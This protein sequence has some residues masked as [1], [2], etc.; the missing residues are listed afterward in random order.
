MLIHD[1][2]E[3][4][5]RRGTE[6]K[7][8]DTFPPDVLPMWI[9]DTDFKCPQPIV[10]AMV[11]RAQQ[12]IYG[13]PINTRKFNQA[14][15]AWEKKRFGWEVDEDWVEFTPAVMPAVVYA[16]QMFTQAGDHI[17]IQMPV[18]PPIH[19]AVVNNGRVISNNQL[20]LRDGQYEVDFHDLEKRLAHPRA[21]MMIL[22]HPHNPVGKAFTRDELQRIG[23]LCAKH[24]VLLVSDEIHQD[25][26]Y[27]GHRHF[28]FASLSDLHRDNSIICINPS[29]TFNIAGVRTGAVIIPNKAIREVYYES[30]VNNKAYGRT[31]FGTLPFE[32]AYNECDYYADQLMRYLQGNMTYVKQYFSDHI[33]QIKVIDPQ[34]TYL[35]WLDCRAL[36]L[37]QKELNKLMLERA[38]VA[39]NDG[40]SF[41]SGGTGFLRLNIA[42]PRATLKQGL[43]RIRMA[44]NP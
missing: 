28:P 20:C 4:V 39:L 5:N 19:R 41:G 44:V 26:V 13:Y 37:P 30:I 1:F 15:V 33:P 42:C 40:D 14:V 32:T 23:E 17:V 29:K 34:A 31:V 36:G 2:D 6:C 43:D 11:H 3:V 12:G 7:K 18:Y 24:H 27:N 38:K 21:K 22:C 9:A 10:D 8:Y 16:I 25:I 35:I